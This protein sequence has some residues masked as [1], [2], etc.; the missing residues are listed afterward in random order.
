MVILESNKHVYKKD[1]IPLIFFKLLFASSTLEK[2]HSL[3]CNS[4]LCA[5]RDFGTLPKRLAVALL[6][7]HLPVPY[8]N[9]ALL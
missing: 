4:T 3:H 7:G 8:A 9:S 2:L 5:G 1:D 6:P